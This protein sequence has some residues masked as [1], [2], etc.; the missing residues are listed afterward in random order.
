[1]NIFTFEDKE[2]ILQNFP[3]IK[4]SYENIIHNKVESVTNKYDLYFAIPCGKKCFAWFTNYKNKNVCFIM[5]LM[6][7]KKISE[8]KIYNCIFNN[9]LVYGNGT[10]LYGTHFIYSQNNF[11]SIENIFY[12]KGKDITNCDWYK[13]LS[14]MN[15]LFLSDIQQK[16]YSN[17]YIVF[18]LP[19]LSSSI[20][21]LKK[22]IDAL[23]FTK[24]PV[25]TLNLRGYK[26]YNI[27]FRNFN[28]I[29]TF[30]S[31]LYKNLDIN[32]FINEATTILKP[33]SSLLKQ[34]IKQ[35]KVCMQK[36]INRDYKGKQHLQFVFKIK[37]DIQNDIYH[38]YCLNNE[39]EVYYKV[40]YIPDFKTSVM[41]NKLFRNIKENDNLDLL[42]E[43]D[44]EEEFQNEREDI[45]VH[46]NA[47]YK[48]V[49]GFNY[50]FKKWYPL[51]LAQDKLKII[52]Q[53]ELLKY[54]K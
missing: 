29:N 33:P 1:M 2:S 6:E 14:F 23:H 42:E 17:K 5:Q 27:Q 10:I 37:P 16:A 52:Q 7:N 47:E 54:D 38:L 11:F 46:L 24:L 8:I 13:K 12:F 32:S 28:K 25:T 34:E 45:F 31:I 9:D 40:A 36:K 35:E 22:S 51:S 3:N 19:L 41:M 48:M 50:K 49:C 15:N 26:I 53:S 4:L 43:S 18:G 30:D 44:D 20:L 39:E 21:E